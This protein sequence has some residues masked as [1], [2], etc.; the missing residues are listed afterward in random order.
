MKIKELTLQNIR[1][2]EDQTVEFPEGT[3]LVHGENGA[4]KTS[5]LMGI[6]GG[7]FLSDI[8]SAGNQSFNLDDLVRR[9]ED[10][11][12]IEL[13]FEIDGG[14][15][16]VEWTFYTTS[17]GPSATLTSPALSEP[18]SQV[19][20]VKGEIQ[21]IL[22]M[23][24]D[25]FSASVYVRQGEINR[26]IDADTRTELI[27]S[28]LNLDVID[29]YITK[30]EGAKRGSKRIRRDNEN[31]R[32]KTEEQL[33]EKYDRDESQF[34]ADISDLTNELQE[35]EDEKEE[36]EEFIHKLDDRRSELE[37]KIDSYEETLEKK[38]EKKSQIEDTESSRTEKR[39]EKQDAQDAIGASRADIEELEEDIIDL[40]EAVE[41]D[42]STAAAVE[43]AAESVQGEYTDAQQDRT[44]RDSELETARDNLQDLEVDL[45]DKKGE[46]ESVERELAEEEATLEEKQEEL[47]GEEDELQRRVDARDEKAADFLPETSID[48]VD[49][50]VR[51]EVETRVDELDDEREEADKDLTRV[52]TELEQKRDDLEDKEGAL[53][54]TESDL[55]TARDEQDS[56]EQA[57][58]ELESEV[59]TAK[60]E[61][62][63]RVEE[64]QQDGDSLEVEV[65]TDSLAEVR[66]ERIPG[67][68]DELTSEIESVGES[69]AGLET[70]E[71]QL[72]E[73]I[74]EVQNLSD[75][76]KCPKC[77]QEVDESY[78]EDEIGDYEE[79]RNVPQKLRDISGNMEAKL[80]TVGMG[81][82]S[83][84]ALL[85]DIAERTGGYY[86]KNSEAGRLKFRFGAGGGNTDFNPVKIL[87]P[88]HFI[89][90][91]VEMD[92][93]VN[94]FRPAETK[95]SAEL[96]ASGSNGDELLSVWRY[97]LGRVAAF[98]GGK[99]SLGSLLSTDPSL[100]SKTV[101][102]SVGNPQRKKE[103]WIEI[104]DTFKPLKPEVKASY[105]LDGLDKVSDNLFE[106]E[107]SAPKTGS[108]EWNGE[109]YSYNYNPEISS[110][111]FNRDK[112]VKI[113]QETGGQIFESA[114]GLNLEEKAGKEQKTV[115]RT[116]SLSIYFLV[117][118]LVLFLVEVG[119]RKRKG[120]L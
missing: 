100:V 97:G 36:V 83:N 114:E 57:L 35:R 64:F 94:N 68:Q 75:Q 69:I 6:F 21:K 54:E 15:Y 99:K 102:W 106:G 84:S 27:D 32:E 101:S 85:E 63:S 53:Q 29:E 95:S 65:S 66:D 107:L 16:T 7:L 90:R 98:T 47:S 73:D 49:D 91:G 118:A 71:E 40:D 22:G 79:N 58:E 92:G 119:Y 110:V 117:A 115:R 3:I 60:E 80:I 120:K 78:V 23:D 1:S 51:D 113:A 55:E 8:T 12:H 116:T 26:L 61:F 56:S 89:T 9:G 24:K 81:E 20:N 77:G 50:G 74:E 30:M 43:D 31:Y 45:K 103:S 87:N 86:L 46:L 39:Q 111:G 28:L 76:D 5:L 96:L 59:E 104:K 2:Y 67:R 13:V 112:T 33:E 11:A 88:G 34:E 25:D 42:L 62:N 105:K 18:V 10:K 38:E 41:Y 14:D 109:A 52:R 17:T 19:S 70:R 82:G 108:H 4:G 48:D 93:G 44:K 72:Q 37:G